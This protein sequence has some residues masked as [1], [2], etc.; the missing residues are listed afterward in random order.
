TTGGG[1]GGGAAAAGGAVVPPSPPLQATKARA[2]TVVASHSLTAGMRRKPVSVMFFPLRSLKREL[3]A[4]N[5][6]A[7]IKT[8]RL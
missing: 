4:I 3:D 7:P 2:A 8:A 1:G 5:F 6:R